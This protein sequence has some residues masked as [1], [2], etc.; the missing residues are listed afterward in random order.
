[1][2][3]LHTADWHLG[4]RLEHI[5]RLEEQ[6]LVLDEICEIADREA[7]DAILIAGDLYDSPNPPI[8]AIELFYQTLK[9]LTQNGRR[10]VIGIAGNHDAPD[11]IEAPD[12]LARASGILLTGYPQAEIRPFALETGLQV[13]RSAPGFAE[14]KLPGQAAP[15]RLILT[16][17]ANE[18]R[19]RRFLGEGDKTAELRSLLQQHWTELADA[20]CDE[21]GV[22][23]LMTHLFVTRQGTEGEELEDES[24][25]SILHVGGAPEMYAEL[26]PPKM[27][28]VAL[29][30]LHG[31]IRVQTE[32]YPILY[33]SSPLCYSVKD[34][35]KTKHVVIVEAEAGQPAAF[36]PVP[37]TR[38]KVAL[39]Q[40]CGS[41]E[42]ALTW[43]TEHPDCLVELTVQTEAHLTA[44][45]RKALHDAHTGI[46][47]LIPEFSNPDDL[48]FTS[49]KQIDLSRNM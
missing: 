32:P 38:G 40:R 29:G 20:Y 25:R 11:R 23:V 9:R 45:D 17:Y 2:K 1:M 33:S 22:N 44:Q 24:E 34:R 8:E 19:L 28:Y 16:P 48:K 39:Q 36:R 21:A 46:V 30:H 42:E 18:V 31:L 37:L 47:R 41:V 15:L 5:S 14:L 10:P 13:L 26:F 7:V 35:D 4:K 3:I 6:R 27:N 43:L 12:P 49:G